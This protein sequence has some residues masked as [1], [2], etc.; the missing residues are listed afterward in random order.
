[1]MIEKSANRYAT[2]AKIQKQA[3]KKFHRDSKK[4][5]VIALSGRWVPTSVR[6]ARHGHLIRSG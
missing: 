3:Q 5:M 2:K 1:V 4:P 6:R